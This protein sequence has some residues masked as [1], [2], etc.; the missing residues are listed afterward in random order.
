[1]VVVGKHRCLLCALHVDCPCIDIQ[2]FHLLCPRTQVGSKAA[3]D[4]FYR[5]TRTDIGA[6]TVTRSTRHI[7]GLR[8]FDRVSFDDEQ[9]FVSVA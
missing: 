9:A 8:L 1:M 3:A 5:L 7:D 6:A 2:S 4:Q